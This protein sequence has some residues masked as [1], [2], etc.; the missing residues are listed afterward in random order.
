MPVPRAPG[1]RARCRGVSLSSVPT[2]H[3]GGFNRQSGWRESAQLAAAHFVSSR[4][5]NRDRRS[6]RGVRVRFL[7]SRRG[8]QCGARFHR[9]VAP[10][11]AI[12]NLPSSSVAYS[13]IGR[14][15]V[16]AKCAPARQSRAGWDQPAVDLWA[17]ATQTTRFTIPPA[18]RTADA[19]VYGLCA[20]DGLE[21]QP[22]HRARAS[23]PRLPPFGGPR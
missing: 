16:T 14:N 23:G 21:V 11:A 6:S 13:L 19:L 7:V 12:R 9:A 20:V 8:S 17:G 2:P 4:R 3:A 1:W 10:S 5:L 22:G 18:Q 15:G